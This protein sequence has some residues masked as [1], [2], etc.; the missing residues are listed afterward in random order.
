MIIT[1]PLARGQMQKA[2]YAM[3]KADSGLQSTEEG[4]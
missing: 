2:V 3:L 1:N 4:E